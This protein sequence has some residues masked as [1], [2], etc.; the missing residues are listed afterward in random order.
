[1][2]WSVQGM[3]VARGQVERDDGKALEQEEKEHYRFRELMIRNKDKRLYRSMMK[4]RKNREREA[5]RLDEK[6]KT[7]DKQAPPT[8]KAKIGGDANGEHYIFSFYLC[9]PTYT[10]GH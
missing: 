6:R 9:Q 5:K 7:I 3:A 10:K 8:K 1:M 2:I 4:N